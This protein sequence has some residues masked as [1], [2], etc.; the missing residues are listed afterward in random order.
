MPDSQNESA[1]ERV[2]IEPE[3]VTR[4]VSGGAVY[5][6]FTSERPECPEFVAASVVEGLVE[7]LRAAEQASEDWALNSRPDVL[8]DPNHCEAMERYATELRRAALSRYEAT[9]QKGGEHA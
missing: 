7:A 4:L 3:S 6:A 9:R 8:P 2:W 1:P 5:A